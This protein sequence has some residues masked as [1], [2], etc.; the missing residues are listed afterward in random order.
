MNEAIATGVNQ[1]PRPSSFWQR[2]CWLLVGLVVARGVA[3]AC[4]LPPFEGWDE[5]QHVA[6]VEKMH[7]GESRPVLEQAT[8][9]PEFLAQVVA[10]PQPI[11]ALKGGLARFGAIGHAEFQARFDPRQPHVTLPRFRGG[12]ER[13]Y[14][15]Q[16][17]PLYYRLV[18]PF[19]AALGGMNNLRASVAGLRL[20]NV[21][22]TAAA[23]ALTLGILRRI[24]RSERL[25][26]LLALP[27]AAHPLFL[28]NAVRVANDALGVLMATA[29]VGVGIALAVG[30]G[31]MG[32]RPLGCALALGLAIGLA[33]QAKATNL[34]LLPFAAACW[35]AWGVREHKQHRLNPGRFVL[36]GLLLAIGFLALESSN[37]RFNLE[38][39]ASPAAMQETLVN[40]RNGRSP[41]D[42][43]RT[44]AALPWSQELGRLWTRGLFFKGGWSFVQT[45]EQATLSYQKLVSFG[46]AGWI[47]WGLGGLVTRRRSGMAA[48]RS[49]APVFLAASAPGLLVVLVLGYTAA[50]GYHMVQSKLAWGIVS[51]GPWYACPA[52]PWFLVLV[53]RGGLAWPLG[54]CREALPWLLAATGVWAELVGI[55]GAM[56]PTYA[57]ASGGLT[58]S[59]EHL[60]QLQPVFLGTS[61]LA[62]ALAAELLLLVALV[63]TFRDAT[64]AESIPAALPPPNRHSRPHLR[65]FA[66]SQSR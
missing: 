32:R 43:L 39:Y 55:W 24:T 60:A 19:Y 30:L 44:A 1:S 52:L 33:A 42:L 64:R 47:V 45:S 14:Q 59:L 58:A 22:L 46:L 10:F 31:R 29:A 62:L 56:I 12:S 35:L 17:G 41:L 48:R 65:T 49:N 21:G 23:V 51:T 16:H 2:L 20:V 9:P 57:A 25:A 13:L 34:A 26:A 3:A 4:V 36:A 63:L 5:Y 28:L 8:I 54:R 27:L 7:R 15:A 40:R 11:W 53:S 61:T 18:A 66:T 6:Y 38:H 37:L 50:L